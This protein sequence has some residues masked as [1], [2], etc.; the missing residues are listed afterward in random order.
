M[1]GIDLIDRIISYY[2][3][4]TRTKKWTI[5][6]SL[7]LYRRNFENSAKQIQ[8]FWELKASVA[9]KQKSFKNFGDT[10]EPVLK[11]NTRNTA[12]GCISPTLSTPTIK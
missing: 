12:S 2:Q 11:L 6:V 9:Y 5:K 7:H 8:Q 1:G 3:I 4:R 10:Y